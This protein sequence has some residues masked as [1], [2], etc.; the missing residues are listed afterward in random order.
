MLKR[1][2]R[3][4]IVLLA[5]LAIALS[6]LLLGAC[7]A[8]TPNPFQ[9][10]NTKWTLTAMTQNGMAQPLVAPAPT[11]EF[12]TDTLG[13]N[14]SCNSYGGDYKTQGELITVST[15]QVTLMACAD[16]KAMAQESAYLDA[17]QNARLFEVRDNVLKITYGEGKGQLEFKRVQ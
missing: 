1:A 8:P 12:Q 7:A 6:L 2:E 13:G 3:F 9:L 16:E 10:A 11:L 14:A 5:G 17:L 15:L 4:V